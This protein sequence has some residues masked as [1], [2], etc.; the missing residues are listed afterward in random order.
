MIFTGWGSGVIEYYRGFLFLFIFNKSKLKNNH[1]AV[2]PHFIVFIPRV[3]IGAHRILKWNSICRLKSRWCGRILAL[4]QLL[5][6]EKIGQTF[7]ELPVDVWNSKM[8]VTTFKW[9]VSICWWKFVN[10]GWLLFTA[11][12][13]DVA[14]IHPSVII[15]PMCFCAVFA[16][17]QAIN[18]CKESGR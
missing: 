18:E 12:D 15:I 14:E 10:Y 17:S 3:C 1:W 13:F 9:G 7:W 11:E 8:P 5:E 4:N 16:P 2:I 6:L